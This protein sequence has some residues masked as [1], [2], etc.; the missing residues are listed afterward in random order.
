MSLPTGFDLLYPEQ[1]KA[2]KAD[3][4]KGTSSWRFTTWPCLL[5]ANSFQG[6]SLTV[7]AATAVQLLVGAAWKHFHWLP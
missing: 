1:V 4:N 5:T 3:A 6:Q 7:Q 2:I